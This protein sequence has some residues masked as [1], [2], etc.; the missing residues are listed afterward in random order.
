MKINDDKKRLSLGSPYFDKMRLDLDAAI[1]GAVNSMLCKEINSGT[2]ALKLDIALI[3]QTIPDNNA[4]TG[5]R[6]AVPIKIAYKV[7]VTLQS[8]A[9]LKGDVVKDFKHEL[10]Q[11]DT[12]AFY[13]LNSDEASGQLNMFNGYDELPQEDDQDDE[14]E[15]PGDDEEEDTEE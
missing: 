6:S 13:I 7:A 3:P 14:D 9:E 5:T 1:H 4:P 8:K 12:K 11:D 10:V 15:L 2:V